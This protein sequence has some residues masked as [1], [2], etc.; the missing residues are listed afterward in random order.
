[1]KSRYDAIIIGAGHNGLVAACYLAR[2]GRRV[3]LLERR[4]IVGGA[5]VTEEVFPGFKVSTAAYVNSLFRQE[6]VEDL[7]L[8]SNGFE[9]LQRNPSSFTPTDD[10]KSLI[11]G[12][13]QTEN[14]REIAKFS[15]KDAERYP[16]YEELLNRLAD[17]VEPMT[18]QTPPRLPW[19]RLADLTSL[20]NHT[21]RFIQRRSDVQ[22]LARMLVESA[23]RFLDKW[24]ESEPLRATLATDAVIGTFAPPSHPGCAYVLLHHVM[25]QTAGKRGAWGYVRG[26][27]GALTAALAKVAGDLNVDIE[28]NR[29]VRR[30]LTVGDRAT[31][32]ELEDGSEIR[33]SAVASCVDA[34]TTFLRFLD[35]SILPDEFREAVEA[36]DYSSASM[37]INLALSE[38]PDFR[39]L[40]GTDPGPQHRGTIHISPTVDYIER[41][42]DDAKWGIPSRRPLLECTI[43]SV[44]DDSLAPPGKHVMSIFVQYAPYRLREGDWDRIGDEFADRC[45]NLLGEFAP[46]LPS[47]VLDR[48]I[49]TPLDLERT[50]GLTGGNIFQGAM[51]LT[52]LFT[53][54]PV[55]GWS[56]YRTPING[57]FLCG[58]AAHPGGGVI[59]AAGYNAARE[60]IRTL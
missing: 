40:P 37:K 50:F 27:M 45:I 52:Q 11:L 49:L 23:T 5:C 14:Q 55:P 54:R 57:L 56:Q 38:L 21:R 39:A 47:A 4:E 33:A 42:F 1:M 17:L 51:G 31:G 34:N 16:R 2:A 26:G 15:T 29:P 6:I 60:I 13:D 30:I 8:A 59:G 7:R 53:E 9:V 19:P 28:C 43:P 35:P 41:A 10:G 58:A 44:L 12:P 24:F 32:V 46:N 36:I 48:H 25:G 18:I 20:F 22:L 3:L